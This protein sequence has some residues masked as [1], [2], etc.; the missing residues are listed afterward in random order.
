MPVRNEWMSRDLHRAAKQ[1]GRNSIER[2]AWLLEVIQAGAEALARRNPHELADEIAF[3]ALAAGYITDGPPRTDIAVLD[4][5]FLAPVRWRLEDL[6]RGKDWIVRDCGLTFITSRQHGRKIEG[7]AFSLF[8]WQAGE[9]LGEHCDALH[10]CQ[11]SDCRR[12]F[13]RTRPFQKCCSSTCSQIIRNRTYQKAHPPEHHSELR[14]RSY[15]KTK[16]RAASTVASKA[17]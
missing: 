13:V 16:A 8:I 9:V 10:D 6:R 17:G 1:V 4:R 3:F 12:W 15:R 2:L 11:R 5:E 7:S 14:R